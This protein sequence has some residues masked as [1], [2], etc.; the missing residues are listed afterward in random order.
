MRVLLVE[1]EPLALRRLE[2]LAGEIE[3]IEIV[4][5]AGEGG[6]ALAEAR[7]LSP[8][9]VVLDVEMP[10]LNGIE[11]AFALGGP[12]AP[13]IVIL[14]AFDRY[15]AQAFAVEATDY[16]LKPVRPDRLRLAIARAQRRLAEK[17]ALRGQQQQLVA[18]GAIL[19]VPGP[20]G[21]REVLLA[22]V[23]WI[24]AARDYV[25]IHT[26]AKSHI[27]R[28]TM[29]EMAERLPDT[30]PRIHRSAFANIDH[31][32]GISRPDKGI[33]RLQLADGPSLS[34]G[35]SYAGHLSRLLRQRRG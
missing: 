32:Q 10:G 22:D 26:A 5:T 2:R 12:D 19:H 17:A 21:G 25:L 14:T 33:V 7:R 8:D 6:A 35:P 9:L 16:L 11:V 34:V 13:Q 20:L 27:V 31:V 1:D 23:I 15:A 24:E 18:A 29:A 30:I 28:S 3:G 4:G